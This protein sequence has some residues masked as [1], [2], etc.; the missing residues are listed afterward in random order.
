MRTD[1]RQAVGKQR[2]RRRR[3][4]FARRPEARSRPEPFIGQRKERTEGGR[5]RYGELGAGTDIRI[6]RE[7]GKASDVANFLQGNATKFR[8]GNTFAAA[9]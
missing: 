2:H 3:P 7:G 9:C 5:R 4:C 1:M 6:G 8:I